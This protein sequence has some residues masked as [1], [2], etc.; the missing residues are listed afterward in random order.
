MC[1]LFGTEFIGSGNRFRMLEPVKCFFFLVSYKTGNPH[2]LAIAC[3]RL[4]V[5][6]S[7][8]RLESI[9]LGMARIDENG[10]EWNLLLSSM[11]VCVCDWGWKSMH[12]MRRIRIAN[13][14]PIEMIPTH[15]RADSKCSCR[16][17][18][19]VRIHS[20]WCTV[21]C[22]FRSCCKWRRVCFF[23]CFW[24]HFLFVSSSFFVCGA[25]NFRKFPRTRVQLPKANCKSYKLVS[26]PYHIHR[27]WQLYIQFNQLIA[28]GRMQSWYID[29]FE[30]DKCAYPKCVMLSIE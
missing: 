8:I 3:K 23:F 26:I 13:E 14:N 27:P 7:R 5:A 9:C 19:S 22:D 10:N 17:S 20:A 4:G 6:S 29:K 15:R 24:F 18:T 21:R 2:A 16:P 11:C 1:K 30:C 12:C 25:T 28:I